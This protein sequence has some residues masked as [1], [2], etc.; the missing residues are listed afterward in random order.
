MKKFILSLVL[1][2]LS[3]SA[4]NHNSPYQAY[5]LGY[6]NLLEENGEEA[7]SCFQQVFKNS[8][9]IWPYKGFVQ[10]LQATSNSKAIIALMPKLKEPFKNDVQMQTIFGYALAESG[11][12][13]A[14]DDLFIQLV[15]QH[16][17][18]QELTYLAATAYSKTSPLKAI[19]VIEQFLNAA[20]AQPRNCI[21]YFLESQLYMSL[22]NK[23]KAIEKVKKSVELCD[24]LDKGWL[25]LGAL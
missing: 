5:L 18:N 8:S 20:A 1:T 6:Y 16:P 25:L 4:M 13:Q 11:N 23:E 22:N 10:L 19:E 17:T 15:N 9:S 14:A 21:F 12:Q 2:C 24:R 3:I 7:F